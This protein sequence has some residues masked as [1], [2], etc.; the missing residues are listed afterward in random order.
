M[1]DLAFTELLF[2]CFLTGLGS[3]CCSAGDVWMDGGF[4]KNEL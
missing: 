2:L 1:C 3:R 4:E